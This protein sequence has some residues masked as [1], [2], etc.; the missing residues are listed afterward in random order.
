[1]SGGVPY[2]GSKIS[3]ISKSEIRYEGILYTI[4]TKESTVA[5]A[6]VR[7]F[8]TEDRPTDRPVA[9][10]DEVYEYIIFRA[11]DI[12]DLHVCEPPKPQPTLTGGLPNDPAIV[13]VTSSWGRLSTSSN[14]SH[15]A[16]VSGMP[17]PPTSTFSQPGTYGPI[18]A[19]PPYQSYAQPSHLPQPF[20]MSASQSG[21][22][23]E[24][25]TPTPQQRK[26][27]TMDAGVQTSGGSVQVQEEPRKQR[28]GVP[29]RSTNISRQATRPANVQINQQPQFTQQQQQRRQFSTSNRGQQRGWF[30]RRP[31][32]PRFRQNPA[33]RRDV[34]QFEGEYDFEQANAEFQELENKLART[35]IDDKKDDSGNETQAGDV[36]DEDDVVYYDRSKS[37][38]DNISCEALER[39]KG[40]L[41]RVDWRRERKLNVET[42]GNSANLSR[43]YPWRGGR[44]GFRGYRGRGVMRSNRGEGRGG[45]FRSQLSSTP[46]KE[47]NAV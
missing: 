22:R 2:L 3:L 21:S 40:N 19:I 20:M 42:F 29:Q 14:L 7:S 9:P 30:Q 47:V 44:G 37:F 17:F 28:Q 43:R 12:K 36:Q 4:D 10:R 16:P 8:G 1:M 23:S 38:F 35:K 11:S 18:G 25:P 15:S 32:G 45:G 6:K 26:S 41:R 34:L 5:L 24:T 27:P 39:S 13:Q 46:T 33:N 31:R